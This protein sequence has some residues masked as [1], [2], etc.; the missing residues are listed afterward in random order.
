M[1]GVAFCVLIVVF[2]LM[3]SGCC[4]SGSSFTSGKDTYQC[5]SCSVCSS[6]GYANS[7]RDAGWY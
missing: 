3:L 5:N 7:Y 1:R 6:C 2:G 4:T